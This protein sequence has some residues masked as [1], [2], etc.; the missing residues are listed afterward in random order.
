M[1]RRSSTMIPVLIRARNSAKSLVHMR[2]TASLMGLKASRV[3]SHRILDLLMSKKPVRE[4]NQTRKRR[5]KRNTLAMTRV[6][7]SHHQLRQLILT[8]R[9]YGQSRK[10]R[11]LFRRRESRRSYNGP[12]KR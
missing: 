10:G 2:M 6:L 4:R 7:V 9:L 11:N 3:E 1:T 8:R 12:K 5:R